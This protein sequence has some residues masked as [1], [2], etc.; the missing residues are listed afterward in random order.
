MLVKIL[1][2]LGLVY[3][4][5]SVA[6]FVGQGVVIFPSRMVPPAGPLPPGAE[7][8]HVTAPDGVRLEGVH[9]PAKAGPKA[10]TLILGFAGNA[11][12]A[13]GIAEFLHDLYPAYPVIA[14][15]YRGY[16]PSGGVTAAS[17]LLDDAP[18]LFDLAVDRVRPDRVVA[19]G[20]SLGS[21]VAAGLATRRR[22]DGL[23]LVTPFDSVKAVARDAFPW[24]PVALLLRHDLPSADFLRASPTPVA[25]VAAGR[26]RVIPPRRTDALRR[27][28]PNLVF[29]ATIADADHNDIAFHPEFAPAMQRALDH[30]EAAGGS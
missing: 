29:D 5:I 16:Q 26:D 25:I 11:S 17:A 10:R 1:L 4:A 22:L 15:Y 21:G 30:V 2:G 9:I 6:L 24:L 12:N 27:A 8:L 14:F 3:V 7:M 18:L 28:A 23:V 13:Q 20:I 19:V